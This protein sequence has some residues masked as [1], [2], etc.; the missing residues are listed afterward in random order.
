M[1]ITVILCTYNRCG[2]LGKTL[3]SVAAS[4]LPSSVEW[5]VL[6]VDNNSNDRTRGVVENFCRRYDGLFRYVFEPQPG[7]SFALNRGI[8]EARGDVLAFLDDDVTV[9]PNWLHNLTTF[10]RDG[11]WAGVGGRTLLAEKVELPKWL[12]IDG[13]DGMGGVL[14]AMFDLGS[15]PC[16]LTVA[17]YGANMAF[18]KEMFE[19]YGLFRTDLGPSPNNDIPRPNEDTEFGRR[20]MAA[21]ERLRYEPSAIAYH[22]VIKD[23]LQQEYFLTSW[24]D[25]GRAEIREKG[26]RPPVW[27]IPRH[28]FSIPKMIGVCLT[29]RALRWMCS[30]DPKR[31]FANKCW[32]RI[33]MGEIVES[34]R[35]A[36]DSQIRETGTMQKA[37]IEYDSHA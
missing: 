21:G 2:D 8:G 26:M 15:E 36:R 32:V 25:Y 29:Q 6:V 3:N 34:Y 33:M 19:K 17:P 4:K 9:E 5:E 28:Y 23:R 30:M 13:S 24:F 10:L 22:P 12:T 7:K 11:L 37:S 1:D 31:R 27:G 16:E 35:L 14:A 20:L 18:R